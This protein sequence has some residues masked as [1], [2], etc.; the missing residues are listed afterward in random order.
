MRRVLVTGGSGFI[1]RHVLALLVA[2]GD[3]EVHAV[4]R[5]RPDGF[6]PG[7][8][9]HALDLLDGAKAATVVGDIAAE[10]LFH[11]A[12]NATPG[13]YWQ[14]LDNLSWVRA[15]LAL[16]EAFAE[17]GG[18][19]VVLAG[20]CAE[21]DW[22][23]GFCREDL[24]P[25][26]PST[27]YGACKSSL[28]TALTAY[29]EAAGLDI[30]WARI[31]FPYGPFERP[32]R[33]IPTVV[34]ALLRQEPADLTEG[35]Q[36]RDF[37]YVGDVATALLALAEPK[38]RGVFNVGTG[39]P[40]A[41]REL[42][43]EIAARLGGEHLL[44]FGARSVSSQEPPLLAGDITKIMSATGWQPATGMA[45]GLAKTLSYW[46]KTLEDLSAAH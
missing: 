1:G 6:P 8:I 35:H 28:Q 20:T 19:K 29:G 27:L 36:M 45:D 22:S 18:R 9:W 12:W 14:A 38:V 15:S 32:E 43:L 4:A 34:R 3:C 37:I 23:H 13:R 44:R 7:I 40:V 24:T 21:Y 41:V 26:R 16:V 5:S 2:R 30:C 42:A 25:I 31:F 17:A 39:R 11:L 46:K 33:F 10:T